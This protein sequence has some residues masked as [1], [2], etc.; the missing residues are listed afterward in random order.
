MESHN[1]IIF[2]EFSAIK[3]SS[4]YDDMK[5]HCLLFGFKH[6]KISKHLWI[7]PG[8]VAQGVLHKVDGSLWETWITTIKLDLAFFDVSIPLPIYISME[9]TV[10]TQPKDEN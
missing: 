1:D 9:G 6:S 5:S 8:F 10:C 4:D 7:L 2:D 3:A